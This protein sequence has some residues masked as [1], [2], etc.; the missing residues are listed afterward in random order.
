VYRNALSILGVL[1]LHRVAFLV[2]SS[3]T[4]RNWDTPVRAVSRAE[5]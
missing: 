4:Q 1:I 2:Q 5:R 3:I